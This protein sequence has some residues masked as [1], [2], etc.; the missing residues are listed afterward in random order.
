MRCIIL[1]TIKVILVICKERKRI[2]LLRAA[3]NEVISFA[4]QKTEVD[5][6]RRFAL[7]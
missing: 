7:E 3:L 4:I 2:V 5:I 1:A 6:F